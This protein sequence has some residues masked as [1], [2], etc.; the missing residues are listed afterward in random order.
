MEDYQ[1]LKEWRLLFDR[2]IGFKEIECWRWMGD[3]Y[4]FGVQS[5]E[6]GEIGY[7]CVIGALGEVFGLI[8][9]KGTR[10]LNSYLKI[11]SL[12][13]SDP[14]DVFFYQEGLGVTFEDRS[15]LRKEDL[16]IIKSLGLKFRGRKAW[17]LFRNLKPGY[18]PWF[19]SDEERR[20]LTIVLEQAVDVCL[21]V[22]NDRTLLSTPAK[23]QYLIR[24]QERIEDDILLWS[25][26][27]REPEP[28]RY[29]HTIPVEIDEPRIQQ[30][31][32]K[33][34]RSLDVWECDYFFAGMTIKGEG[35]PYMPLVLLVIDQKRDYIFDAILSHLSDSEKA[36]S[37]G[38]LACIEKVSFLPQEVLVAKDETMKILQPLTSRLNI[39]LK[40]VRKCM[41]VERA[42]KNL[43]SRFVCNSS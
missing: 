33:V 24:V 19:I 29:K 22:K 37:D 20:F 17:P 31:K 15:E 21:R 38:F 41:A 7:C 10:G 36:F 12:K 25:D 42:K 8:V 9:Y 34:N 28:L 23:G 16:Q 26:E 32:R 43:I 2:A 35:R 27:Y 40:R 14:F 11:Q 6:T 4:I 30:I 18:L 39:K 1:L 5:P 13:G 3:D